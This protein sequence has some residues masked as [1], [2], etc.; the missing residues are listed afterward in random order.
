MC[1]LRAGLNGFGVYEG[2]VLSRR[3]PG[4]CL[5]NVKRKGP[6]TCGLMCPV[7]TLLGVIAAAGEVKSK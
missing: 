3:D 6:W 4:A 7:G 1:L 2:V 5:P